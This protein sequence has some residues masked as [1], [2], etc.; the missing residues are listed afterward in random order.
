MHLLDTNGDMRI[1]SKILCRLLKVILLKK[2][3]EQNCDQTLPALEEE[4][5]LEAMYFSLPP[6]HARKITTKGT[7]VRFS[8]R[9]ITRGGATF[10]VALPSG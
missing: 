5:G 6:D 3:K 7:R 8:I 10:R 2:G 1:A 9:Y 4:F